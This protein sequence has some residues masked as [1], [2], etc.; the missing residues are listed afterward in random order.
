MT[1]EQAELVFIPAPGMG[2]IVSAVEI[3]KLLVARD[4]R[5]FIS[6]LVMKFPLTDSKV[7]SHTEVFLSSSASISDRIKFIDLPAVQI[8]GA[9]FKPINFLFQ[10][11]E[12]QKPLV[13]D[14][15]KKLVDSGSAPRVAGFVIDMFCT[16]MTEVADEFGVPSYVFFTSGAGSL[17][18]M[19]HTQ[20]LN[21]KHNVD[22][23][24][25]KDKPDSEL[26]VPGFINPVPVKVLPGVLFD[27]EALPLFLNHHRKMR[28]MKG[29]LVNTFM[30][31]ESNVIQSLSNRESFPPIY[32][33]GPILNLSPGVADKKSTEI[34]AW[35]DS[36]PTS[37]V[38]F[39]CFGSMGCFGED[40]V[41]EIALALENSGVPFLW[42]LRQPPQKGSMV[43]LPTDYTDPNEVLPEG[44]LDRTA[45][46][47]K[48]IGWAPQTTIL[49]HPA[50]GGFVSH[51]GW[52]SILESLWFGVPVATWP[53]YAEQQLNA[54][55][56]VRELGLAV[57][58][59]VDYRKDF[60]ESTGND[61][62]VVILKAEEIERGIRSVMVHDCDIRK[63]V[64]EMSEKSRKGLL[65]GGASS[66]LGR[67]I[68]DVIDNISS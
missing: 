47:G 33:V 50:V 57:E 64:K 28:K 51:C 61:P 10:F 34:V 30:E 67:F 7:S 46:I 43:P 68:D 3:A 15:V 2:H 18:L 24:E 36:Q 32:P 6:V 35:L 41:K 26:L 11:F 16:T 65:E 17:S 59:K 60:N 19:F 55:Q 38:V 27:K 23:T 31:L 42:S 56:L 25:L 21:D 45:E 49:A 40:Q 48:V 8:D 52:N 14:A 62:G 22:I 39:L 66:F 5:L 4:S 29:I 1:G 13:R 12:D 20:V 63:K 54:F 53:L 9:A 58:I 37:S 44:F